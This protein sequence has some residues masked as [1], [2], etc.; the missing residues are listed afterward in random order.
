YLP[1]FAEGVLDFL[2]D[3]LEVFSGVAVDLVDA[4]EDACVALGVHLVGEVEEEVSEVGLDL[5]GLVHLA[6]DVHTEAGGTA[7]PKSC[8]DAGAGLWGVV[9]DEAWEPGGD[10]LLEHAGPG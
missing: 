2:G 8:D 9:A 4:D 1:S 5:Q 7:D 6:G 3:D 10:D